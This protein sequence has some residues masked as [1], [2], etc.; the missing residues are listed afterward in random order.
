VKQ[1]SILPW[2]AAV[3]ATGALALG[4]AGAC[5]SPN[6]SGGGAAPATPSAM[7]QPRVLIGQIDWYVDYDRALEVARERDQPLWVHF[8]E[9]PG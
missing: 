6:D 7:N 3:A 2:R 8:G 5:H 9:H 4:F 1:P